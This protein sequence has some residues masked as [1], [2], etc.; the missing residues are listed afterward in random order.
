MKDTVFMSKT[1]TAHFQHVTWL[2]SNV[3]DKGQEILFDDK[4]SVS[5]GCD[6]TTKKATTI[7]D[8]IKLNLVLVL[9]LTD[10]CASLI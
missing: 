4:S 9:R 7:L 8:C 10:S 5:H 2:N 3:Y 6:V 1:P